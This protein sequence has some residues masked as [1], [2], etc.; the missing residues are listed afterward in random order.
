M[1]YTKLIND[2]H[3]VILY[4]S[5]NFGEVYGTKGYTIKRNI[6]S[7][8]DNLIDDFYIPALSN[9]IKYKR[10]SGFSSSS[11]A[12]AARGMGQFILNGGS[13]LI[14]SANYQMQTLL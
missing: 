4:M 5:I 7:D 12:V 3:L 13:M 11:L 9:S 6:D 1:A 8:N 10:I 14:C 2:I